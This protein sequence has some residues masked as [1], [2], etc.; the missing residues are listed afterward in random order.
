MKGL[1]R[2]EDGQAPVDDA[3]TRRSLALKSAASALRRLRACGSLPG[4]ASELARSVASAPDRFQDELGVDNFFLGGEGSPHDVDLFVGNVMTEW[5]L[6]DAPCASGCPGENNLAWLCRV[7]P[8]LLEDVDALEQIAGTARFSRYTL[9]SADADSGIVTLVDECEP[10]G[11]A[12][13]GPLAISD[14]SLAETAV[15]RG[16]DGGTVQTHLVEVDGALMPFFSLPL[17]DRCPVRESS[18]GLARGSLLDSVRL[19]LG[20]GAELRSVAP[21]AGEL[22]ASATT[23]RSDEAAR[24]RVR[25]RVASLRRG[26]MG[27]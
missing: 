24:E 23:V 26:G 11:E 14:P 7:A 3:S 13:A 21:T 2:Q 1:G 9:V 22:I 27:R 18:I 12:P 20:C 5:F 8:D 6:L 10:R 25:D 19:A 4:E 15:L 16:W 17:Y